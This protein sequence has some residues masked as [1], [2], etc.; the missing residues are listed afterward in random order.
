V[1]YEQEVFQC[2]AL[3][4]LKLVLRRKQQASENLSLRQDIC[5]NYQQQREIHDNKNEELQR[6]RI[7]RLEEE[8]HLNV[9]RLNDR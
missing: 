4:P 6:L 3:S 7:R 2:K 1:P 8:L 5:G 9:Q